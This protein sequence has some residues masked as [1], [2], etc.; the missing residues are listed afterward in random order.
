MKRQ[1]W[2]VLFIK[3]VFL[4]ILGQLAYSCYTL[5]DTFFIAFDLGADGL[6]ALNLAF[7]LF[8]FINGIGL[9]L[10]MGGGTKYAISQSKGEQRRADFVFTHAIYLVFTFSVLLVSVGLFGAGTLVRLLGAN[11]TIF[12]MTRTYVRV[13]LLFS[14]AFLINSLLQCFIRNDGGPAFSMAAMIGGSLS[15]ILLD[16]LFIFPLRLGILGAILATGLAPVIS[17]LILLPYFFRRKNHFHLVLCPPKTNHIGAIALYGFPSLLAEASS[18]IVMLV[19]NFII[20]NLAG[21]TGVAAYGVVAA[22]SLVVVAIY[23]GLSQGVQPLISRCHGF[24]DTVAVQATLNYALITMLLLSSVI[25]LF[26]FT[27]ASPIAAAFNQEQNILL[28][29]MAEK[30][31]RLYFT[32]CPFVGFNI[33]LSTY[34]SSIER[35]LS[36]HILSF[37]RGFLLIIPT[38]FILSVIMK[39][40][41]VYSA[42]PITEFFVAGIGLW[43]YHKS[44]YQNTTCP[45]RLFWCAGLVALLFVFTLLHFLWLD[46]I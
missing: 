36:A 35:P 11:D 41:G 10:G 28:Q 27:G 45:K 31:L 23:T 21:N 4:N 19:F 44:N 34:F 33:V 43:F 1:N 9:M 7:P 16:Y 46:G 12:H 29:Q 38:A 5:A 2:P 40:H 42:Y 24:S 37:L 39:I 30:G 32:A 15:N 26:V 17:I 8:C 20:L 18:G 22:V 6:A 25:E 3:Y 13:L 14:P